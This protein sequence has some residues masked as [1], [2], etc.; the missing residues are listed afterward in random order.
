V[1]LHSINYIWHNETL[2][3][4]AELSL[5]LYNDNNISW[6]S[7]KKLADIFYYLKYPDYEKALFY[8]ELIICKID[9]F[10]I[11]SKNLADIYRCIGNILLDKNEI[12]EAIEMLEQSDR[13]YSST[14]DCSK[15]QINIIVLLIKAYLMTK[16]IKYAE[17][18]LNS[19]V[20][21]YKKNNADL[22]CH[23]YE[24]LANMYSSLNMPDKAKKWF[25]LVFHKI[26]Y[27]DIME[28]VNNIS[29]LTNYA[30]ILAV[31]NNSIYDFHSS[32]EYYTKAIELSVTLFPWSHNI[33]SASIYYKLAKLYTNKNEKYNSNILDCALTS[34]AIYLDNYDNTCLVELKDSFELLVL[35][36]A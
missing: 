29:I 19:L 4:A 2:N 10:S 22:L 18:K 14:P 23:V 32:L 24:A 28:N 20:N 21:L 25:E 33:N 30:D 34:L 6:K 27:Q 36:E 3:K 31:K 7:L 26:S 9:M 5:F 17:K 12:H 1:Y 8:Y 35:H 16:N 13:L 15:M 11:D